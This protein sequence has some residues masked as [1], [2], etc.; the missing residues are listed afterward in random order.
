MI[1]DVLAAA[2]WLIIA[3]AFDTAISGRISIGAARPDLLLVVGVVL[4]LR[5]GIEGSAAVGFFVGLF[6]SAAIGD[7]RLALVIAGISSCVLASQLCARAFEAT[8]LTVV[9]IVLIATVVSRVIW[10]FVGLPPNPENILPWV[11]ATILIALYNGLWAAPIFLLHQRVTR[12]E[13]RA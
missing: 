1:R 13:S 2:V 8:P 12:L 3:A 10:L 9:L 6:H 7:K 5:L 4:S 11:P